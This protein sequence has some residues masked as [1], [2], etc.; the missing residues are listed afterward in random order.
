MR[1]FITDSLSAHLN[2]TTHYQYDAVGHLLSAVQNGQEQA[3][4]ETDAVDNLVEIRQGNNKLSLIANGLNQIDRIESQRLQYDANGNLLNDGQRSY[5]WDGADRLIQI[6]DLQTGVS[7]EFTYD[8]YS[9]RTTEIEKDAN[10]QIT[11]ALKNIWCGEMLCAQ[12]NATSQTI[13]RFFAQGEVQNGKIYL[14]AQDQVGSVYALIDSQGKVAGRTAYDPYGNI[15]MQAGTQPIM[16]YAGLYQHKESGLHLATYRAYNSA[17]A[18]WL[19]RDPIKE[20]GGLNVYAYVGGNPMN[21]LDPDGLW[22]VSIQAYGGL[23]GSLTLGWS[24]GNGIFGSLQAG[25]G[26]GGGASF[27]PLGLLC[28]Y[29]QTNG[30]ISCVDANNNPYYNSSGYAGTGKGR[31][32]P[33][34][35]DQVGVGPLTRGDWKVV[36]DWHT[37]P[38][39]G[40]NTIVILPLPGNDCES[41]ERDCAS[42]RIHGNNARNDASQGCIVLPP[43]RTAIPSG[44]IIRV[45]E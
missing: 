36:G 12:Q 45:I 18:R 31:N 16:A 3:G 37:S 19:N 10:G 21:A 24:V 27:D 43:D 29:S 8:G 22:S 1:S 14:Y 33:Q 6:T 44:E 9:R 39:T 34:A 30:S 4:Y 20:A 13:N 38:H 41:T 11:K 32:N 5:Q 35:Q 2:G 26:L 28:T 40:K 25:V 23:G 42:F 15:T 17:T 7:S